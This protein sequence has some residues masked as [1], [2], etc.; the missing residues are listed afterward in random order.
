MSTLRLKKTNL[1][2]IHKDEYRQKKIDSIKPIKKHISLLYV[3]SGGWSPYGVGISLH[4]LKNIS[5]NVEYVTQGQNNNAIDDYQ[6]L[7]DQYVLHNIKQNN[8]Y[9]LEDTW[10]AYRQTLSISLQF[11]VNYKKNL[12]IGFGM[13]KTITTEYRR[14]AL[15][16]NFIDNYY[17]E[18]P[19][20]DDVTQKLKEN[21]YLESDQRIKS[22]LVYNFST[23]LIL[24]P[25]TFKFGIYINDSNRNDIR[26]NIGIGITF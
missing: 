11:P 17:F 1:Y 20:S 12:L 22:N 19:I 9:K 24:K 26:A 6:N 25:L 10:D 21:F 2:K 16:K 18:Y 13:G 15:P 23:M 7:I 8:I 3:Y 4:T 5:A 14:Y